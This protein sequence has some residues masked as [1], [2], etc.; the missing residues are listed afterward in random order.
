MTTCSVGLGV[1]SVL[2]YSDIV[3]SRGLTAEAVLTLALDVCCP[4]G[5]VEYSGVSSTLVRWV[6]FK[7]FSRILG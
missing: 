2:L 1:R 7:T 6:N 4:L 5:L 3:G